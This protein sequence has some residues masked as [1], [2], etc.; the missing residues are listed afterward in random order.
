MQQIVCRLAK[1]Q[2]VK[3][4]SHLDWMRAIERAL[5]RAKLP[6]AYTAGFNPH[7]RL[8]FSPP[9]SVGNTSQAELVAAEMSEPV[10]PHIF[11]ERL[12]AVVP[13]GIEV[14]AAWPAP[15][16][17]GKVTFG[18]LDTADYRVE[19]WGPVAGEALSH[20]LQEM[21]QAEH[22]PYRRVR[23]GRVKEFDA[24]PLLRLGEVVE[25]EGEHA[26]LRLRLRLGSSGALRPE[27]ML[28][29]LGLV[30]PQFATHIHRLALFAASKAPP[31]ASGQRL[32]RL[33]PRRR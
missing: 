11:Q 13:V 4:I 31:K 19:V 17:G 22:L 6:V 18:D 5:R 14:L 15:A 7:P 9:L 3:F 24:R 8:A 30:P 2:P 1:G 25:A 20:R 10:D 32:S 12:A 29:M 21:L 23:E 16:A 33:L 28:D 26:V 27:E